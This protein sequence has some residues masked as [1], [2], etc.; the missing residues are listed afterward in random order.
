MQ[1]P[2]HLGL[3]VAAVVTCSVCVLVAVRFAK[4]C[5]RS[6]RGYKHCADSDL[7]VMIVSIPHADRSSQKLR[8]KTACRG[9]VQ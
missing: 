9:Q 6:M 8:P 2:G 7:A 4:V 3:G 5:T 1:W